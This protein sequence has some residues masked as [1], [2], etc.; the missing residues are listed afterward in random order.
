MSAFKKVLAIAIA[1]AVFAPASAF[2]QTASTTTATT[3]AAAIIGQINSL[4]MQI[5]SLQQQQ[6]QNIATLVMTLRQGSTGDQVLI[7]QAL[8]AADSAIYPEGIVSGFFGPLTSK[9]VKRFQKEHGI[10]QV[11]LV[12]PK[13]LKKL[14]ELL[15]KNPLA[16]STLTSTSTATSTSNQGSKK[17]QRR[18]C[19][20]ISSLTKDL[21]PEGWHKK[22]KGENRQIIA[23]CDNRSGKNDDDD[24]RDDDHRDNRGTPTPTPTSSPTPTPTTS[25][26]PTPTQVPT[27]ITPP[28]NSS[29]SVTNI[30]TTTATI[31][32]QTNEAATSKI[33][34]GTATPVNLLSALTVSNSSLVTSHVLGLTGLTASTTYYY[35]LESKDA[36]GNTTTTTPSTQNFSTTN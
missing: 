32:W 21:L 13:T 8:L 23:G 35:V 3:S 1:L 26:T 18:L 29:V 33:Y 4:Q 16:F 10:E 36:I 12:G 2:A 28:V 34:Y 14:Q 5:N 6:Q 22:D 9:A 11:G 17:D 30:A 7:L 20:V 19:A 31:S 25:P 24:D 15:K 27:D